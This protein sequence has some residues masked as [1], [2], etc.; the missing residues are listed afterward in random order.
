[1]PG[2]WPT[3]VE[4]AFLAAIQTYAPDVVRTRLEYEPQVLSGLELPAVCMLPLQAPD[5]DH[6]TGPATMVTWT[7][8]VRLYVHLGQGYEGAQAELKAVWP[9]LLAVCR[10]DPTLGIDGVWARI[11]DPGGEPEFNEREEWLMKRLHLE[12]RREETS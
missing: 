11:T 6:Q 8:S 7:W 12:A 1:M 2:T 5:V 10:S 3:D 4:A 9:K